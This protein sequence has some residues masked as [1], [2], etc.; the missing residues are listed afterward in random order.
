MLF[1]ILEFLMLTAAELE[2]RK[3]IRSKEYFEN[4]SIIS[5]VLTVNSVEL[6]NYCQLNCT[7]CPSQKIRKKGHLAL[8]LLD[9]ILCE[10]GPAFHEITCHLAMHG[11]PT[12]HPHLF[13]VMRL[14]KTHGV[15]INMPTNCNS[16]TPDKIRALVDGGLDSIELCIDAHSQTTYEK[17][18]RGGNLELAKRNIR[19]YLKYKYA[20]GSSKP[21][22]TVLIVDTMDNR[23]EIDDIVRE[24]SIDGVDRIIKKAFISRANQ[25]EYQNDRVYKAFTSDTPPPC[26]WLWTSVNILHD[27]SVVPCCQDMLGTMILG[28]LAEMNLDRIT[29]NEGYITLRNRHINNELEGLICNG[30]LDRRGGRTYKDMDEPDKDEYVKNPTLPVSLPSVSCETQLYIKV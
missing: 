8:D 24:W 20:N 26:E 10:N 19:E 29:N 13:E 28:N 16:M 18:R 9:K 17:L 6:T 7:F 15:G 23:D 22:T 5:P 21:Y 25:V 4:R 27:G 11:E 3:A 30:C 12:L 2:S 14:F 1:R